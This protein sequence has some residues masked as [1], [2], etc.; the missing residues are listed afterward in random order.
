MKDLACVT[1]AP[2]SERPL[3]LWELGEASQWRHLCRTP[4]KGC[5]FSGREGD[6]GVTENGG[7]MYSDSGENT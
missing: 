3:S 4:E 6:Y 1:V 5:A 2:R 7:D